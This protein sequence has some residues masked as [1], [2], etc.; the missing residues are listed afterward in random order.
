MCSV[1][2]FISFNP[3]C[4][5]KKHNNKTTIRLVGFF[6]DQFDEMARRVYSNC[7]KIVWRY[8]CDYERY[9]VW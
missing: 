5:A 9:R 4:L 2:L 1:I 3:E 8:V 6:C 7:H